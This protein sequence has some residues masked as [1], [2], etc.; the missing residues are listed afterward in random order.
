MISEMLKHQ[1]FAK[2]GCKPSDV[3]LLGGY[4][5][6]VFEINGGKVIKILDSSTTP[7][8]CLLSELEWLDYLHKHGVRVVKPLRLNEDKF[9]HRLSD[10][11]YFV[12][13]EKT[14]GVHVSPQDLNLWNGSLFEQWGELMGKIHSL[15]KSFQ[16]TNKHPQW[17]QNS[18]LN[19]ERIY[20]EPLIA[21]KW[22]NYLSDFKKLPASNNNYG[23]IHGDLHHHNFLFHGKE[24]TLI[25]FGD[26]EYHWFA[27]DIAIA[28]YHTA[29]IVQAGPERV[30]FIRSFLNS[31]MNGYVRANSNTE[32]ISQ[33]DYF[34]DY[35]HLFSYTY[36][37]IYSDKSLLTEQNLAYLR[38]MRLDLINEVSFLGCSVLNY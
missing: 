2:L 23:L 28:I 13:Y 16:A 32:F 17:S 38:Q 18:L 27:Y 37:S 15:A 6:N 29:Q 31:F 24:L 8:A 20:E 26:A 21:K 19:D 30:E 22:E 36:H 4:N 3:K 33:I 7:E 14:K 25:D 34:I 10:E 12:T 5:G 9:I 11:F 1:V 35:R